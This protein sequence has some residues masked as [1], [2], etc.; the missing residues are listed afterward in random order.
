VREPLVAGRLGAWRSDDGRRHNDSGDKA[1]DPGQRFSPAN[2]L[3]DA[4]VRPRGLQGNNGQAS[5]LTTQLP[6]TP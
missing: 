4:N 2:G 5:R 6:P 1:N 3:T